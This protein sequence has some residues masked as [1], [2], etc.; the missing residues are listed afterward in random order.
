MALYQVLRDDIG[1]SEAYT[2]VA[3]SL[4]LMH[5]DRHRGEFVQRGKH[6]VR[7]DRW[8]RSSGNQ[9]F[10]IDGEHMYFKLAVQ[11]SHKPPRASYTAYARIPVDRFVALRDNTVESGRLRTLAVRF[12]TGIDKMMLNAKVAEDGHVR[13][14]VVNDKGKAV[15][16]FRFRDCEPIRGNRLYH[17]VRWDKRSLADLAGDDRTYHLE[18][19]IEGGEIYAFY[20]TGP[21]WSG[22]K[23]DVTVPD[24]PA[25]QRKQTVERLSDDEIRSML[26]LETPEA[27]DVLR[28]A[29]L[30]IE[31]ALL[32]I[33]HAKRPGFGYAG[34]SEPIEFTIRPLK[35]G[36]QWEIHETILWLDILTDKG[37][38]GEQTI[39][40][41]GTGINKQSNYVGS[42]KIYLNTQDEPIEVPVNYRLQ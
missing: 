37:G 27:P 13:V 20:L 28:A 25:P 14:Q 19:E 32:R 30:E 38:D 34:A 3:G 16:G 39:Q 12:E 29:G 17:P 15:R 24:R 21:G 41:I 4:D 23:D 35:S 9:T 10:Y 33:E 6:P 11:G 1:R 40:A 5:W 18:F 31:P 7:G 36:I 2:E 22:P 42:L 8:N 26:G